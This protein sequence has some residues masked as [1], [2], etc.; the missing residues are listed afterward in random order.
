MSRTAA[1]PAPA[2]PPAPWTGV[3]YVEMGDGPVVVLVHCSMSGA[4]QWQALMQALAP[5]R[6]LRAVN[7]FGYGRTPAWPGA[8]PPTLDDYAELVLAAVPEGERDIAV[9]GHSFGGA[10]AMQAAR[11]LGARAGRLVL[12]EPSL[13]SLLRL[14]GRDGAFAEI[15]GV[16]ARMRR[17]A[18]AGALE[19]AARDF[20]IYWAGEAAWAQTP[21]ERQSANMRAV[22]LVLDE[23]GAVFAARPTPAEWAAALPAHTLL[24]SA[25]ATTRAAREMVEVLAE[26][27][28][29]WT[30]TRV[31]QGGHMAPIT[32]AP[33]V[34]AAI[35]AFLD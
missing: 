23:F 8:A 4:R 1:A 19:A 17:Q 11:R 14:A 26:A 10:V 13:F 24:V 2:A 20:I 35:A 27:A 22:A 34:N 29:G 3:D 32:H 28:P 30:R 15:A 21:P 25:P 6:R 7:L 12:L 16:A 9:I 18:E 5:R 31:A 33:L